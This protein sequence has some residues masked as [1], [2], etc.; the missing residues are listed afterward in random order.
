[1]IPI[2][3]LYSDGIN[4]FAAS[5]VIFATKELGFNNMDL[6]KYLIVLTL[7]T[8][9]SNVLCIGIE[10]KFRIPPKNLLMIHLSFL[11][12][13]SMYA[14][15]G[16]I[17]GCPFGLVNRIEMYVVTAIFGLNVG[18]LHSYARSVFAVLIPS[19]KETEFFSLYEIT[20]KGS[21]WLGTAVIAIVSNWHSMRWA[22]PYVCVF[23]L[24]P[25]PILWF[26]VNVSDSKK[27]RAEQV[28][29]FLNRPPTFIR[30]ISSPMVAVYGTDVEE[31]D[32][33][34]TFQIG[35][36]SSGDIFE[37][38]SEDEPEETDPLSELMSRVMS[39]EEPDH[40]DEAYLP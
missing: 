16:L 25:I 17:P 11:A 37:G 22:F 30:S 1:M 4:T 20:N 38:S 7:F 9:L 3:F 21:S 14:S 6:A 12:A 18:S 13:L 10:R 34:K 26:K 27:N 24:L 28:P 19:G 39:F 40:E 33:E 31:P 36:L 23:F 32:Q 15:L 5:A 8:L 29:T 35:D 2:R